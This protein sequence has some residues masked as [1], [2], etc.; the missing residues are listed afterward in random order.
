MNLFS[1]LFR[2]KIQES[3]I[4]APAF[5]LRHVRPK[6]VIHAINI[7]HIWHV[8]KSAKFAAEIA[9]LQPNVNFY[10]ALSMECINKIVWRKA[11]INRVYDFLVE[12]AS[13]LDLRLCVPEKRIKTLFAD[14]FFSVVDDHL[15]YRA[16]FADYL[17]F[18]HKNT[19]QNCRIRFY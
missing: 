2:C 17:V 9:F 19:L 18:R 13:L 16:D 14:E 12:T 4:V 1:P 10:A 8:D 5:H 3:R 7:V 15:H 6:I 11:L